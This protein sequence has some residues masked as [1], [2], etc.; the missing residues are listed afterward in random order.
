M[1]SR[2]F[3][4]LAIVLILVTS[5][6][7]TGCGGG[8]GANFKVSNCVATPAAIYIG[9][10]TT[11]S[12]DISNSGASGTYTAT[13]T[14][15]GKTVDNKSVE[16]ASKTVGKVSFTYTAT[17]KG[18]FTISIGGATG[19]LG[20]LESPTG[21]WDVRYNVVGGIITLNYS[22]SKT[23]AMRK[24]V[25]LTKGDGRIVTIRVN[26]TIVNGARE[27]I[28]LKEGWQMKSVLVQDGSPGVDMDIFL[29]LLKDTT[30]VLYVESGKGDVNVSSVSSTGRKPI[31][32]DTF[33]TGKTAPA[34]SML[35][36]LTL[37]AVAKL[38]IGTDV[39]LP[40]TLTFT[41]GHIVNTV[42]LNKS[43]FTGATLTSD[44]VAF[45]KTGAL[46]VA[47]YVGTAGTIT[48][49]GTGDCLGLTL[50]GFPIDFQA[51][52]KLVLEPESVK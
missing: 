32:A 20:I 37:A 19:T 34:G 51:E 50:V 22:L 6:S 42:S 4:I 8:G 21:Y 13:L 12:A 23:T 38:N 5:L 9:D 18:T 49:T 1:K 39:P 41:T 27:V 14:V 15:D 31:Q 33:A 47:D 44:G 7:V 11:I 28:F 16:V 52:I 30:G 45:A 10:T 3:S 43:K 46:R 35:A 17:A 29:P 40:F 36:T 2:V 25:V 24:D 48:T 26:K